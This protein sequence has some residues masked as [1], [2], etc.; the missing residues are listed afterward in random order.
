MV[1]LQVEV[2]AALVGKGQGGQT[3][4]TVLSYRN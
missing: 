1:S 4:R 2:R 3:W